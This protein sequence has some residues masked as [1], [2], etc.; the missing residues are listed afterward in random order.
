MAGRIPI[1]IYISDVNGIVFSKDGEY[2]FI[3]NY[4]LGVTILDTSNIVKPKVIS[5]TYTGG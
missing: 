1:D 2:V 4:F 5:Q 3:A